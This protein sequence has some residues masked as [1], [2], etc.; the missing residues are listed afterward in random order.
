MSPVSPAFRMYAGRWVEQSDLGSSNKG[1]TGY[2]EVLGGKDGIRGSTI[3]IVVSRV[4][5][6]VIFK[7]SG[8]FGLF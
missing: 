5:F 2:N 1:Y 8:K 7:N 6:W 4:H 3:H